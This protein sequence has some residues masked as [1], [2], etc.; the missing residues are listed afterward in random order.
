MLGL[1]RRHRSGHLISP[2]RKSCQKGNATFLRAPEAAAATGGRTECER[3]SC[4]LKRA[5]ARLEL[6]SPSSALGENFT[7]QSHLQPGASPKGW[8]PSPS[9]WS[10]A[11][12][13]FGKPKSLFTAGLLSLHGCW[14]S[15]A[16]EASITNI[17]RA[18]NTQK[19]SADAMSKIQ[20]FAMNINCWKPLF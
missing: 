18:L 6:D 17:Y 11:S 4:R 9:R 19:A 12:G 8:L 7:H 2:G 3:A 15:A 14:R 20:Y 16:G 5:S 10:K 13:G 1:C